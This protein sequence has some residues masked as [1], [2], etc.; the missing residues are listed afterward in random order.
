ML[1]ETM[2]VE[3]DPGFGQYVVNFSS[4]IQ[5][6]YT[7]INKFKNFSQ[8]KL[9]FKQYKNNIL[10][11]FYRNLGFYVGCLLWAGYIKTLPEQEILNN[12][13]LGAEISIEEAT[14][15]TDFM[16]TFVELFAKDMKYFAG[17][18]FEFDSYV[19]KVLELYKEF[20]VLNNGFVNSKKNNDIKLPAKLEGVDFTKSNEDIDKVL[21]TGNL[22]N[23]LDYRGL[24]CQE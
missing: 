4:T 20:L 14:G 18:N 10:D 3:F 17:E 5:Y 2:G 13:C 15:E 22:A 11:L 12:H 19:M 9:R 16:I 8:K 7:D 24:I 6:L 1:K 21:K 23:L